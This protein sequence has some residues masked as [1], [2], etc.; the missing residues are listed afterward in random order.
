MRGLHWV[1]VLGPL[2]GGCPSDDTSGTGSG[3][4]E[5]GMET[6]APTT[7]T[8]DEPTASGEGS[9]TTSGADEDSG[10]SG[11]TGEDESADSTGPE[12]EGPPPEC[13]DTVEAAV[14]VLASLDATQLETASYPWEDGERTRFEFLPPNLAGR[15]G[16]TL[17]DVDDAQAALVDAFLQ[18]AMSAPG[19]LKVEEIRALESVLAMQEDGMPVSDNRDPANYFITFFGTPNVDDGTA[20]GWRFE[21]HHLSLHG[22]MLDCERFS[23]TPAFWG[24]SPSLDPIADEVDL[25]EQLWASLDAAAQGQAGVAVGAGAVDVRDGLLDPL[26]FE[27]IAAGDL[28]AE[29]VGLLRDLV[30]EYAGNMNAPVAAAR[31][32]AIE[33]A[34]FDDV[35]FAYDEG[36]GNWRVLGPTFVIEFIY[37]GN[38][39]VHSVWRDYQGDYGEDLIARHLH[40]HPH[41]H[42]H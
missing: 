27:G 35:R 6:E 37:A 11:S 25:S 41:D 38:T 3:S 40:E 7:A 16:L 22:S 15:N 24:V 13:V 36:S 29:S 21:G 12:P 28:G 26:A 20:W 1:W 33:A 4:G 19:A 9:A 30:A 8:S 34:G 17:R 23:A 42:T 32:D 39:H 18:A 10:S 31:I 5:T 2:L 14:A